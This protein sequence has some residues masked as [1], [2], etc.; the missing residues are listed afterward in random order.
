MPGLNDGEDV[1]DETVRLK[2]FRAIGL[3]LKKCFGDNVEL[4]IDG[5]VVQHR[6]AIPPGDRSRKRPEYCFSRLA[7]PKSPRSRPRRKTTR[8]PKPRRGI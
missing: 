8:T 2:L 1:E 5:Y 4:E 7:S 6:V 3:R